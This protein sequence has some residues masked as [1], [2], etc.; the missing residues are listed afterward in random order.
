MNIIL[1]FDYELYFGRRTGTANA[2]LIAPTE[3]LAEMFYKYGIQATF[4]IDIGYLLRCKTLNRE[5]KA[6]EDVIKQLRT[7][8][9]AGHDLQLHIHPHWDEAIFK[10]GVWDLSHT[11]YRLHQFS[12][13]EVDDIISRYTAELK[14]ITGVRPI[15]YRAG[16]WCIQPFYYFSNE[17]FSHGIRLDSTI[18]RE[19]KRI[20]GVHGFDFTNA[21]DRTSWKF[22]ANPLEVVGSGRYW[23]LPISSIKVSPFFYWQFVGLKLIK[24]QGHRPYG[25]GVSIP[26]TKR[27]ITNLLTKCSH[28]VVSMDGYK[29]KLLEVSYQ[30][31]LEDY[32]VNADM[33]TIGHPKAAT[34]FSLKKLK[35]FIERHRE[36][37]KFSTTAQ[38]YKEKNGN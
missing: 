7:L 25:D 20:S 6:Y 30:K 8:H 24:K 3:H 28:S 26:L 29:S 23:E 10:N 31:H 21:P 12:K 14:D 2:C 1:T 18:Y 9:T 17:L 33:V 5:L 19:G 27:Q 36:T 35:T 37:D 4:Y 15:A 13:S 11:R 16:G 34:D 22:D 38:W 32:G